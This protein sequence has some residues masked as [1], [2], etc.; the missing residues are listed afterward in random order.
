MKRSHVM[1]SGEGC[2]LNGP[3]ACGGSARAE[4]GDSQPAL[5][6]PHSLPLRVCTYTQTGTCIY[7]Y[8][9]PRVSRPE[10][11]ISHTDLVWCKSRRLNVSPVEP[12]GFWSRAH[13][14]EEVN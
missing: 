14:G 2:C 12:R 4:A 1:F 7:A 13:V 11:H 5:N 10:T 8:T 6:Q 3:A 9:S